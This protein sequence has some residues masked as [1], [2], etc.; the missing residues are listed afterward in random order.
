MYECMYVC[1]YIYIYIC[2]LDFLL[3]SFVST[4]SNGFKP[5]N[6]YMYVCIYVCMYVF[7]H[8]VNHCVCYLLPVDECIKRDDRIAPIIS[9]V[10]ERSFQ[11]VFKLRGKSF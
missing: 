9:F 10:K 8:C 5:I 6:M 7:V 1:I 2:V 3:S 11:F 4:A